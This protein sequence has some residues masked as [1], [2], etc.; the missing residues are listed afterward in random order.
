MRSTYDPQQEYQQPDNP[1]KKIIIDHIGSCSTIYLEKEEAEISDQPQRTTKPQPSAG[2]RTYKSIISIITFSTFLVGV[3]IGTIV[4]GLAGVSFGIGASGGTLSLHAG[5]AAAG[6]L[7][8]IGGA[9]LGLLGFIA[10]TIVC[11]IDYVT[12]SKVTKEILNQSVESAESTLDKAQDMKNT[13]KEKFSSSYTAFFDCFL[14]CGQ[15]AKASPSKQPEIIV[16]GESPQQ[17]PEISANKR[18]NVDPT[19]SFQGN[20]N[21]IPFIF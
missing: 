18:H 6:L 14:C 7:A 12:N 10:V 15:S 9:A 1:N 4:G 11:A 13:I 16:E 8:L 17:Q 5:I 2:Q 19:P 21:T 3:F 20:N